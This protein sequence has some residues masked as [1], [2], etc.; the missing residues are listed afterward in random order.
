MPEHCDR[1]VVGGCVQ[2]KRD[3]A[4][5]IAS[6]RKGDCFATSFGRCVDCFYSR[7]RIGVFHVAS[8][9]YALFGIPIKSS[10]FDEGIVL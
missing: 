9:P 4:H 1:F 10:M 5:A 2:R 8:L 3:G 6:N 7:D